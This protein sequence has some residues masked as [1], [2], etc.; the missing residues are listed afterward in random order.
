V[1]EQDHQEFYAILPRRLRETLPVHEYERLFEAADG[2][3]NGLLTMHEALEFIFSDEAQQFGAANLERIFHHHYD[4]T[5]LTLSEFR[6]MCAKMGFEHDVSPDVLLELD[7]RKTRAISYPDLAEC[8]QQGTKLG[9]AAAKLL[10]SLS[11]S[12]TGVRRR[13]GLSELLAKTRTWKIKA[14]DARSVRKEL[15][16]LLE[17]TGLMVRSPLTLAMPLLTARTLGPS[18]RT[19]LLAC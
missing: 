11:W 7:V 13:G 15:H 1:W 10:V 5:T 18:G 19:L 8:V 17:S 14:R 4:T 6:A 12:W 3:K 16:A 9:L 2:S